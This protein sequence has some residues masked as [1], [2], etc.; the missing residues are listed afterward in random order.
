MIYEVRNALN[1]VEMKYRPIEE[2]KK[3]TY[4][5]TTVHSA[6]IENDGTLIPTFKDTIRIFNKKVFTN[7]GSNNIRLAV[8]PDFK[9]LIEELIEDSKTVVIEKA[10]EVESIKSPFKEGT[11][12]SVFIKIDDKALEKY[13]NDFTENE[14][15][16]G[17]IR[18]SVW[19][20]PEKKML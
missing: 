12:L 19:Y 20:G 6:A 9:S 13:N 10:Q 8:S 15:L 18:V 1:G 3:Y 7:Y 16:F 5:L 4:L 14:T 11:D 2:G 17:F